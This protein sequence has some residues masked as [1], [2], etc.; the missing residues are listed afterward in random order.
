MQAVRTR[1]WVIHSRTMMA[2]APAAGKNDGHCWC[3]DLE[4]YIK[5]SFIKERD[6]N[7]RV[8]SHDLT[9]YTA[10]NKV[11]NPSLLVITRQSKLESDT[12]DTTNR[13]QI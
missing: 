1:L 7:H 2:N 10:E 3:I 9:T 8:N 5:I 4:L 11:I 12:A 6:P 13:H